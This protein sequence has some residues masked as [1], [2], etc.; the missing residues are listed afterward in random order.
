MRTRTLGTKGKVAIILG[1]FIVA[2]VIISTAFY[3]NI[4]TPSDGVIRFVDAK[5][6]S[7]QVEIW[8]DS[9]QDGEGDINP[10]RAELVFMDEGDEDEGEAVE[11]TITGKNDAVQRRGS[12]AVI[13]TDLK[14]LVPGTYTVTWRIDNNEGLSAHV[15]RTFSIE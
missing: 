15:S 10:S 14:A 7:P 13:S 1:A 2:L 8:F 6:Y 12:G 4:R 3:L 11:W 5:S 9:K